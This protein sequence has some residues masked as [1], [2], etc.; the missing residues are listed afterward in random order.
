MLTFFDPHKKKKKLISPSKKEMENF[1]WSQMC[2]V[3]SVVLTLCDLMDRS[4]PG[5]SV[6]GIFQA[7]ILE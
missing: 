5:F 7:G 1:Y 3:T 6:H 4:L 2:E